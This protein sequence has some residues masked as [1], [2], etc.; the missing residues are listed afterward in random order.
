MAERWRLGLAM[1]T[2]LTFV[3]ITTSCARGGR[4]RHFL[5]LLG[6][7]VLAGPPAEIGR[8]LRRGTRWLLGF[9][10]RPEIAVIIFGWVSSGSWARSPGLSCRPS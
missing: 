9:H 8:A 7:A 6:H 4:L 1:V 10:R 5:W 2:A 3:Q